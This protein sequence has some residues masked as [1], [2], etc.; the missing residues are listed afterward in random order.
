[1]LHLWKRMEEAT[2][3]VDTRVDLGGLN[4]GTAE[5]VEKSYKVAQ[6]T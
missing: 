5:R 2:R 1:M 3:K 4:V 6:N